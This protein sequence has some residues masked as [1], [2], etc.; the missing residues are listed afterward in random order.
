MGVWLSL[1]CVCVVSVG[2]VSVCGVYFCA[3]DEKAGDFPQNIN[4]A[5]RN[6]H[7]RP[8][9]M[10]LKRNNSLPILLRVQYTLKYL[11]IQTAL[12]RRSFC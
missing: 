6:N 2:G 5:V 3:D 8:D 9:Y 10:L 4:L 12:G 11:D 1:V 7:N